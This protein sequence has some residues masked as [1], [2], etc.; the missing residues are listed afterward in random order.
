MFLP[1]KQLQLKFWIFMDGIKI[2]RIV[3]YD[4]KLNFVNK[5]LDSS[6]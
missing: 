6:I 3:K 4:I 5:L 1:Y 2:E